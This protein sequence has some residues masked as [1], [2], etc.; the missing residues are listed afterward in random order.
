MLSIYIY[1][2]GV[3]RPRFI[4]GLPSV[5]KNKNILKKAHSL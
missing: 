5:P 2:M 1:Y 3:G 4:V